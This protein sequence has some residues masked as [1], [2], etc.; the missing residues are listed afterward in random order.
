MAIEVELVS[1]EKVLYEGD[2]EMVVAR[3]VGGGDLAFLPGHTPFLGL[4]ATGRV[5]V[6][7]ESGDD[8][9]IAVH[10][11]FV[12]VADDR[13]TIL[14]EVAELA[15]DIDVDRARRA[16]EQAEQRARDDAEDEDARDALARAETRL[17]TAGAED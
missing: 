8:Q 15:E 12:E 2:A 1:P 9:A 5:L 7:P 11:G 6:R 4:L 16:K 14:S 10:G 13:V 3:T 17:R